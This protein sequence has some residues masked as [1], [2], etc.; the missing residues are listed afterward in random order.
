MPVRVKGLTDVIQIE[1]T[2]G[3]ALVLHKDGTVSAWGPTEGGVL[4]D[5]RWENSTFVSG[6]PAFSAQKVPGVGGIVQLA[7]G[8]QHV[9]A[10]AHSAPRARLSRVT[11]AS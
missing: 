4:G 1:A 9:L 7:T 3:G 6:G 11:S 5:G 8:G 10:H 2:G